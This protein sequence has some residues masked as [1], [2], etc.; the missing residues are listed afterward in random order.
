MRIYFDHNASSPLRPFVKEALQ[1]A[2]QDGLGNPS[3]THT[4]GRS[5]RKVL[6]D[7]RETI[8]RFMGRKPSEIVF[9]SGG[10]EA[11]HLAWHAFQKEGCRAV[12]L[13]VEHP[14]VRQ[15]AETMK[16]KGGEVRELPLTPSGGLDLAQARSILEDRPDFLSLQFA[17]N[18][19][20]LIYGD[21]ALFRHAKD[22]GVWVHSDAVQ[23]FGKSEFDGSMLSVHY[24]S[25]S[26][27]K[28]G[29]PAGAGALAVS[30]S[31]PWEPIWQ[32]GG[33]ERGRRTGTENLLGILGMAAACSYLMENGAEEAA[34]IRVLRDQ[35][36][37]ELKAVISDI[38]ITGEA[39]PRLANTSHI[40]F[41]G[42]DGESLMMAADLEGLD[43]SMGSA[44][45]SGSLSASPV[46]LQMG[47]TPEEARR[48]LRFSLGW[49]TT[50]KEITM[51]VRILEKLVTHLRKSS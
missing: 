32:G 5:A 14:S 1:K 38:E 39:L 21:E 33:Q 26:S 13:P 37:G 11:N 47:W 34:Q 42:V 20:G 36:E 44:C 27:H 31:A 40:K 2:L 23:A 10:T 25:L 29:A 41:H 51:A 15:A 48:A 24:L 50:E 3:S 22:Q 28:L 18:E 4:T 49:N 45:S 8:A 30:S 6:D 9:T 7:A 12:M 35:F 46:L 16:T 17:N 19:T 43:C